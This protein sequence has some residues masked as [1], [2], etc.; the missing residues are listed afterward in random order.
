MFSGAVQSGEG[1][2]GGASRGLSHF[3]STGSGALDDGGASQ[4]GRSQDVLGAL[5]AV[6][7]EQTTEITQICRCNSEWS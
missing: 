6:V 3:R 1:G 5:G 2:A 4:S 7:Q